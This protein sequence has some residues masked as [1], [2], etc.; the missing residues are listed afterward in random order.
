MRVVKS[1]QLQ[2]PAYYFLINQP[3][4]SDV[5]F[6]TLQNRQDIFCSS[7]YLTALQL[8]GFI[9]IQEKYHIFTGVKQPTV[10]LTLVL[11]TNIFPITIKMTLIN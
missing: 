9:F 2:Q 10:Y 4:K 3:N 5:T 6:S 8:F 7:P 11:S 1:P